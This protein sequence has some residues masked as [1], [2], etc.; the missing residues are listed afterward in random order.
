M[1]DSQEV[2]CGVWGWTTHSPDF[3]YTPLFE[4]EYLR[5]NKR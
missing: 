4:V 1:T 5:N 2:V 3:K